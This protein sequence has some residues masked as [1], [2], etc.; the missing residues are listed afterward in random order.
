VFHASLLRPHLPSGTEQ[1]PA[2]S[3]A[4]RPPP[5]L[6]GGDAQTFVAAEIRGK[7]TRRARNGRR[8]TEYLVHWAGYDDPNEDTWE[9][10]RHLRP[11]LAEPSTWRL[12]EAYE[13][14]H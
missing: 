7:R 12:V 4:T 14:A 3:A 1:F 10:A 5:P 8:V 11:P 6:A 9:P 2:R 13:A